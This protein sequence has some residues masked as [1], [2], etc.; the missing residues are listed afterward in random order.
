MRGGGNDNGNGSVN[1]N[2]NGSES[3]RDAVL[4]GSISRAPDARAHTPHWIAR[5]HEFR[6]SRA[7]AWTSRRVHWRGDSSRRS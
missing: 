6:N 7:R 5:S 2:G 3:A 1:V 4:W